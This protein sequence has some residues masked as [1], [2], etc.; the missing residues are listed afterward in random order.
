MFRINS[1][2]FSEDT[3]KYNIYLDRSV[4]AHCVF[5]DVYFIDF[6]PLHVSAVLHFSH[7]QVL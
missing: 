5:D 3:S 4:F 1:H 7:H 6:N 2:L